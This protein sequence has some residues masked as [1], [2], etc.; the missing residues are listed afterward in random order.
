M[1]ARKSWWVVYSASLDYTT[2]AQDCHPDIGAHQIV[3]KVAQSDFPLV[4][5]KTS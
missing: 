4:E 1:E 3:Y 5:P 2:S